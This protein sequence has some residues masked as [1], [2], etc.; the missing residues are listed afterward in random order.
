[1]TQKIFVSIITLAVSTFAHA[2]TPCPT[3][4]QAGAKPMQVRIA[5]VVSVEGSMTIVTPSNNGRNLK[6]A[7][8]LCFTKAKLDK[9][10][11]ASE[12]KTPL[13]LIVKDN[14]VLDVQ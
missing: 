2:E 1:M 4:N 9:V 5:Q 12:A 6:I 11:Q 8:T 14:A 7:D 3:V 13:T 10:T